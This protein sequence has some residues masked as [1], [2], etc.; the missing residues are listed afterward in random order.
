[1]SADVPSLTRFSDSARYFRLVGQKAPGAG[2][3]APGARNKSRKSDAVSANSSMTSL[4]RSH[5]DWRLI[6]T[7]IRIVAL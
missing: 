2:R 4:C 3:R 1:M 5:T 6:D 7:R